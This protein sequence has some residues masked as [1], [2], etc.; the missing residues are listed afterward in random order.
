[1]SMYMCM[2][3]HT[4]VNQQRGLFY[5][6]HRTYF[7]RPTPNPR[8]TG[9]AATLTLAV[10]SWLPEWVIHTGGGATRYG[11]FSVHTHPHR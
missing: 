6:I 11:A 7:F 1:M 2:Y 10:E 9:G 4:T 8:R 3:H 5:G